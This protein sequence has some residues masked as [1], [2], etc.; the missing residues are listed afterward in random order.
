VKEGKMCSAGE[1]FG[2]IRFGSRVDIYLPEGIGA[3]VAVG[4]RMIGGE[5]IIADMNDPTDHILAVEI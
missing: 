1:R 3:K 2:M 5:T 4:Q